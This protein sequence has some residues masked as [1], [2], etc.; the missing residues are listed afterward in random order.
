M[1]AAIHLC[2]VATS[3]AAYVTAEID[4]TKYKPCVFNNL[5]CMRQLRHTSFAAALIP[6]K[7]KS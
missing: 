1:V 2:H 6:R 4:H 7:A 5:D 3:K